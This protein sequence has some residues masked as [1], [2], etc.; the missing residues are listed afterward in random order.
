M[1]DQEILEVCKQE[2]LSECDIEKNIQGLFDNSLKV[3]EDSEAGSD[4][5]DEA[6]EPNY[7]DSASEENISDDEENIKTYA[8]DFYVGRDNVSTWMK[9]KHA[10]SEETKTMDITK[11]I[12]GPTYCVKNLSELELFQKIIDISMLEDIVTHTNTYIESLRSNHDYARSRDIKDTNTIELMAYLG[13]LFLLGL[14][15]SNFANVK[16][17]WSNDGTGIEITRAAMSY[18]RF[19][20]LTRC[21]RFDNKATRDDRRKLDKLAAIRSFFDKFVENSQASFKLSE[22]VTIDEMLHPF[23]GKCAWI[24][25]MPRKPAKYGLKIYALCDAKTFYTFNLEIYCGEQPDGPYMVSNEPMDVVK[26]LVKPIENC[27]RNLTTD[28]YYTSVALADYLL[29]KKITLIGAIKKYNQEIPS[30]FLPNKSRVT[31]STLFGFQSNKMLASYV[32]HKNRAIILLSTKHNEGKIY[33][34]TNKPEVIIDYNFTKCG[35]ET[36]DKLC[37]T[38]TVSRKSKRWPCAIFFFLLNVAGINAYVLY[39]FT[40]TSV[41]SSRRHFLKSLAISLM[42]PH[43]QYRA[44]LPL[45]MHIA[46]FLKCNYSQ[47]TATAE[48]NTTEQQSAKRGTCRLCVMEKIR[49]TASMKCSKCFSFTCKKHSVVNVV[50]LDCEHATHSNLM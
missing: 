18:K 35:V 39:S 37:T 38:Y 36:V 10:K 50:C 15:K 30:E 49:T 21:L 41:A 47:S 43:L 44:T 31:H 27:H 33:E 14:K 23:R 20:F 12:P 5:S 9:T 26:R 7:F 42:K 25:N 6:I 8:K 24:Q 16:E 13:L 40:K 3:E 45:P 11:E 19:L 34:G 1:E 4:L 28:N 48:N 29:Q 17:I 22:F 2:I 32:P 46:A